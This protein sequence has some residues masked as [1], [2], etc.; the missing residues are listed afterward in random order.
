MDNFKTLAAQAITT[1]L[2]NGNW[3]DVPEL[4][5]KVVKYGIEHLMAVASPDKQAGNCDPVPLK[6]DAPVWPGLTPPRGPVE[7]PAMKFKPEVVDTPK[8]AVELLEEACA[9]DASA[10]YS[11][12][13]I[14][15]EG[16][17]Y[18]PGYDW[19]IIVLSRDK[20]PY[21]SYIQHFA[22]RPT[23]HEFEEHF[24]NFHNRTHYVHVHEKINGKF[25]TIT[26]QFTQRFVNPA[27]PVKVVHIANPPAEP[28][29][30]TG[31]DV[32]ATPIS[33]PW[34]VEEKP[35]RIRHFCPE[36]Q[37]I[38][39]TYVDKKPV[40]RE[41]AKYHHTK[42]LAACQARPKQEGA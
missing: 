37:G 26:G 23:Q 18:I 34:M 21:T 27:E 11:P 1:A 28:A 19:Q 42:V 15:T 32:S 24:Q 30:L 9:G 16:R 17:E 13:S 41:M 8:P 39:Y 3:I 20:N 40:G 33:D 10:R 7:Q 25:V 31:R 38:I 36:A 5:E 22:Q 35:F 14:R 12:P 6:I 29:P 4:R 2:G